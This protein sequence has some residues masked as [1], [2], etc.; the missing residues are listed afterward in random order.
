MNEFL[1]TY[2]YCN[3]F[4][5][6]RYF[7]DMK[8]RDHLKLSSAFYNL[9]FMMLLY[10]TGNMYGDNFCRRMGFV[11]ECHLSKNVICRR[12]RCVEQ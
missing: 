11:E 9:F 12:M 6:K 4:Y 7:K 2:I 10:F 8:S 5:N 1:M 3:M